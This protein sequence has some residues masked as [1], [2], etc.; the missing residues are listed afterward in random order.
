MTE[1]SLGQDL[2]RL[3]DWFEQQ[4]FNEARVDVDQVVWPSETVYTMKAMLRD[5]L[6]ELNAYEDHLCTCPREG[7][8]LGTPLAGISGRGHTKSCPAYFV[9]WDWPPH[10]HPTNHPWIYGP[11]GPKVIGCPACEEE[12]GGRRDSGHGAQ[13][14]PATPVRPT[15]RVVGH[16]TAV[17]KSAAPADLSAGRREKVRDTRREWVN[18]HDGTGEHLEDVPRG[19]ARGRTSTFSWEPLDFVEKL[20]HLVDAEVER[21]TFALRE[22][23]EQ[24]EIELERL[25]MKYVIGPHNA[26]LQDDETHPRCPECDVEIK[27]Q[28]RQKE[29]SVDRTRTKDQAP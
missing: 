17:A 8:I 19:Y 9:R 3:D 13:G 22:R 21:R 29:A 18:R 20:H 28:E 4:R 14:D 7:P 2:K 26:H 10:T 25:H 5:A 27:A 24:A 1:V 15:A 12:G 23:A 11:N 6:I 16:E